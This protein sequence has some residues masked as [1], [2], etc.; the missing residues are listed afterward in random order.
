MP[1]C[2]ELRG[3]PAPGDVIFTKVNETEKRTRKGETRDRHC[4]N[5]VGDRKKSET[6]QGHGQLYEEAP[7]PDL[8]FQAFILEVRWAGVTPHR[9]VQF[10]NPAFYET[11][12]ERDNRQGK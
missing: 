5:R 8:S 7:L 4:E 9:D 10:R 11:K 2:D 3:N 12:E 1:S 6:G